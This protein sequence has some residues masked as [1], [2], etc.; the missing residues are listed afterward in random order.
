MNSEEEP[1]YST[2]FT[3]EDIKSALQF[4]RLLD[5]KTVEEYPLKTQEE[6][7]DRY[8]QLRCFKTFIQNGFDPKAFD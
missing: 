8:N 2:T 4:K 5:D 7:I 6:L 3:L 1:T